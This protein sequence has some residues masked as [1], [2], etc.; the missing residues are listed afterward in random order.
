MP[1]NGSY[2]IFNG[3]QDLAN[4]RRSGYTAEQ[5]KALVLDLQQTTLLNVAQTYYAV[6]TFERQV[7]VLINSSSLQ[8]ERVRDMEGRQRPASPVRSMSRKARRRP[9]P[10]ACNSSRPRTNAHQTGSR[11][12]F[13]PPR[14]CRMLR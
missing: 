6:L 3:F 8:N 9:P 1:A 11:W 2:R 14:R 10:P 4:L 13:S 5:R 12:R 7:I